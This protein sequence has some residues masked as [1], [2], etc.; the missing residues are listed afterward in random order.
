M[1]RKPRSQMSNNNLVGG[2]YF[3]RSVLSGSEVDGPG[4]RR[5]GLT[6]SGNSLGFCDASW[7]AVALPAG[8]PAWTAV[9]L[10]LLTLDR[11]DGLTGSGSIPGNGSPS[12]ITALPGDTAATDI[13]LTISRCGLK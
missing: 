11:P 13:P 7:P 10:C 12:A 3:Q 9:L 2:R 5:S 1:F 4:P 6:Q 8:L